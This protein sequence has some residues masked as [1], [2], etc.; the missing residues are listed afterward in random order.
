M[1][2]TFRDDAHDDMHDAS[3]D[4]VTPSHDPEVN[5]LSEPARHSSFAQQWRVS[6]DTREQ[7]LQDA[8]LGATAYQVFEMPERNAMVGPMN[9]MGRFISTDA[10]SGFA[11]LN[12]VTIG[13]GVTAGVKVKAYPIA[14]LIDH[15][16]VK[17]DNLLIGEWFG[18]DLPLL[19]EKTSTETVRQLFHKQMGD[20][21]DAIREAAVIGNNVYDVNGINVGRE[22]PQ[23]IPLFGGATMSQPQWWYN[24]SISGPLTVEIKWKDADQLFDFSGSVE[25]TADCTSTYRLEVG[26]LHE[27]VTHAGDDGHLAATAAVAMRREQYVVVDNKPVNVTLSADTVIPFKGPAEHPGQKRYVHVYLDTD[28]A[29]GVDRSNPGVNS[30][31]LTALRLNTQDK[32]A[33][34]PISYHE[35]QKA[36]QTPTG[37]YRTGHIMGAFDATRWGNII[38]VGADVHSLAL[39]NTIP[40]RPQ[41]ST[42]TDI[43]GLNAELVCAPFDPNLYGQT[44]KAYVTLVKIETLTAAATSATQKTVWKRVASVASA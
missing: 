32:Q 12:T 16:R 6:H 23:P 37:V 31:P 19:L 36:E 26:L 42:A 18:T 39:P 17:H 9:I 13:G 21:S 33:T 24:K 25:K 43:E 14:A 38:S 7:E 4:Q 34:R 20:Q 8:T 2:L 10:A 44:A 30:L 5:Y 27:A 11:Q 29:E 40:N 41:L 28:L 35:A 1:A 3:F 22:L 15:M